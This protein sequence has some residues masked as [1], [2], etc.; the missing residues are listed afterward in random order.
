VSV[1]C[2]V[3]AS[4]QATGLRSNAFGVAQR[5]AMALPARTLFK[6]GDMSGRR[7]KLAPAGR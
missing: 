5:I 3:E 6:Q 2:I 7:I 1:L 4:Q